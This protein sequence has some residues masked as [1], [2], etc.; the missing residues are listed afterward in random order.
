MFLMKRKD[1]RFAM[2][3]GNGITILRHLQKVMTQ[4]QKLAATDSRDSADVL[5]RCEAEL[6]GISIDYRLYKRKE[7]PVLAFKIKVKLP[8][9]EEN[10]IRKDAYEFCFRL[11]TKSGIGFHAFTAIFDGVETEDLKPF[12]NKLTDLLY[13]RA[14][15]DSEPG[16]VPA[17]CSRRLAHRLVRPLSGHR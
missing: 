12:V 7:G 16:P 15:G 3:P 5:Q 10:R 1:N 6:V 4:I 2:I 14:P 17:L 9:E 11:L 8:P 13:V